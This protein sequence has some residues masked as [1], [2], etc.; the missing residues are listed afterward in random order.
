MNTSTWPNNINLKDIIP[1]I[2]LGAVQATRAE[3]TPWSTG[4]LGHEYLYKLLQSSPKHIYDV[5]WIQKE[6]FF[7]LYKWLESNTKLELSHNILIQEQ[8][9]MFL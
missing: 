1:T 4:L 5:L 8:V 2:I 7:E 9:A 3:K 6:T